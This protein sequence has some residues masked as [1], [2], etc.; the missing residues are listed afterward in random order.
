[1]FDDCILLIFKKVNV[2]S[3]VRM[4]CC[5][6]NAKSSLIEASRIKVNEDGKNM[7]GGVKI[8]SSPL[9]HTF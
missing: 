4:G 7:G 3:L 5:M 8:H 1:M 2:S 6:I 9:Q